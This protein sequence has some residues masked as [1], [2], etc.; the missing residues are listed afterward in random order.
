MVC[1]IA[2]LNSNKITNV[3]CQGYCRYNIVCFENSIANAKS[4]AEAIKAVWAE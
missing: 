2:A 1:K 3:I 4:L